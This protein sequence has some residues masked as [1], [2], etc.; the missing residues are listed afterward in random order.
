MTPAENE[1]AVY[2]RVSGDR[3]DEANQEPECLKLC[4]AR[5][6]RPQVL[7][8]RLSGVKRRPEWDRLKDQVRRGQVRAVVFW[9]L[10]RTGRTATQIAHDIGEFWRWGAV[11]VSVRD[12]WLD[13]PAG[14]M[15]DLMLAIMA[16]VAQ[17]E[18]TKLIERTRAG[19][20]M[21]RARGV[22][23]GRKNRH[24]EDARLRALAINA[25]KPLL[26]VGQISRTLCGES[27]G[28]LA[29]S[30]ET[31]RSWL[32]K[33]G[34]TYGKLAQSGGGPGSWREARAAGVY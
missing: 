14:P 20:A 1:A 18:R 19:L 29:I 17:T 22:K 5:G 16:W 10:D 25:E 34:R 27:G 11:V 31:V 4:E 24:G 6:W 3:Q 7:R 12:G 2:L 15:R 23:L 13:Q 8:E 26:T 28:K 9:A 33:E 32:D 30:K 21:A